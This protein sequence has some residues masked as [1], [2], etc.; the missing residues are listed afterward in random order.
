MEAQVKHERKKSTYIR[1]K[2]RL[3]QGMGFSLAVRWVLVV[4]PVFTQTCLKVLQSSLLNSQDYKQRP[5]Q[6]MGIFKMSDF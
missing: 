6:S 5:L 2:S 1:V 4:F 3:L